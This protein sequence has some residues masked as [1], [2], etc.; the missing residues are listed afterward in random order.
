M[1]RV[2]MNVQTPPAGWWRLDAEQEAADKDVK[3]SEEEE[4][5][6]KTEGDDKEKEREDAEAEAEEEEVAATEESADSGAKEIRKMELHIG[7]KVAFILYN[8]LSPAECRHLVAKTEEMGYKPMPEYP[9]S[10][11]SNTRLIID[12]EELQEEIWRRV[13][14]HI[15]A[16]FEDRRGKWHPYGLNARWRF[17][18]YTPGQHFS[19]HCDG[20]FELGVR[21]RSQLTF[22]FYLN[23]GFDGGATVFLEGGRKEV[24]PE[25][26]MVLIFQHNI[27]HEGQRLATDKKYIMRS[28]V[29]YRRDDH[30]PI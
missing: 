28:D 7:K 19:S 18:R 26:G 1:N 21:D 27:L 30:R 4:V 8:V 13:Q 10:Y 20:A 11:R 29:M 9:T 17:C 2:D 5:A 3:K 15:P 24:Q 22:M 23:G 25:A 14:P 6:A 12:D 16:E